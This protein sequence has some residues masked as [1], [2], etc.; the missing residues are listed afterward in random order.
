M[1]NNDSQNNLGYLCYKKNFRR[2]IWRDLFTFF[3]ILLG[4]FYPSRQLTLRRNMVQ[5]RL[6]CHCSII[7]VNLYF[8]CLSLTRELMQVVSFQHIP[9]KSSLANCRAWLSWC[10][11]ETMFI[12]SQSHDQQMS[13]HM[14]CQNS[15]DWPERQ[16]WAW[17][18]SQASRD[19]LKQLRS[20]P[21]STAVLFYPRCKK[22]T[23]LLI[24]IIIL[25]ILLWDASEITNEK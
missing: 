14:T 6:I 9:E 19:I 1:P 18:Y 10:G 17:L 13:R 23:L 20:F 21:I 24:M 7:A 15:I 25:I 3:K 22:N 12:P 2:M 11:N 5:K 16:Q 4:V 8:P